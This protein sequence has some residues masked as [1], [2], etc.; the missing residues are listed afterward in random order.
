[1][2]KVFVIVS[3]KNGN[4]QSQVVDCYEETSCEFELVVKE[5]MM[6]YSK[7]S[8]YFVKDKLHIYQGFTEIR[9]DGL[10]GNHVS[11]EGFYHRVGFL[12]YIL[13]Q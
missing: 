4:V 12:G 6:P 3:S 1:M 5:D 2:G 8:V 7:V 11:I 13:E 9:T 10:S